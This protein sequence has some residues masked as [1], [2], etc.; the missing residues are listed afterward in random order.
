MNTLVL[1]ALQA[2][3]QGKRIDYTLSLN[4]AHYL[5]P[6][7]NGRGFAV[8]EALSRNNQ[9]IGLSTLRDRIEMLGGEMKIFSG[10]GQG[11]RAEFAI[12][13]MAQLEF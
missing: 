13:L 2:E 8:D 12:P 4:H 7:D 6:Q 3:R 1:V 10:L 11:T 5:L 9:R